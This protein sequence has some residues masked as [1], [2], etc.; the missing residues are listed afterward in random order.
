MS[1]RAQPT[2]AHGGLGSEGNEGSRAGENESVQ[3]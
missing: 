2:R 1:E 3:E